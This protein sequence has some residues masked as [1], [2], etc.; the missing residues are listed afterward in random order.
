MGFF[1]R[2]R[3]WLPSGRWGFW[4]LGGVVLAYVLVVLALMWWWSG[5]PERFDVRAA[6]SERVGAEERLV[7]GY[8]TAATLAEVMERLLDKPGGWLINDVAPPGVIMDNIPS[9]EYGALVQA[10]DLARSLRNDFA[11]SQTQSTEDKDLAL[12]DPQFH[13]D[14]GSW[15]FPATEREY[16]KGLKA[17]GRYLGRLSDPSEPDAQFYARADN[18]R[19]WLSLVEL[20]MGSLSQRLSASVGERRVNTDLGGDP[21]ARQATATPSEVL[22]KTPWMET[23][24]VFYEARGAAWALVHFL[25]AIEVD[26]RAVLEDK[27]AL[28]SLRQIIN[29]LESSLMPVRSPIIL[30]GS[31]FGFFSNHSLVMSSYLA[32]ANAAIIDLR[33]LLAQG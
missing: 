3:G 2:M 5:E 33:S 27:N 29:E 16:R 15:I 28:V 17:L 6:A 4:T 26:F 12:V 25:K 31:P 22:V 10:R 7:T 20:R 30:N 13:F 32:R 1:R 19:A 9:F 11:R 18:L 24:D 14:A 21:S 23:D 8:V